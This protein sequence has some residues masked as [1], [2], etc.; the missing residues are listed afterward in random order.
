MKY[1]SNEN[2][3]N[4]REIGREIEFSGIFISVLAS[5]LTFNSVRY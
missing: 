3:L 4:Q 1:K 2:I 5:D